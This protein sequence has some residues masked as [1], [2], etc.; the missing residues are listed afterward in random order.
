MV[1]QTLNFYK[2]LAICFVVLLHSGIGGWYVHGYV[3]VDFF[4]MLSGFFLARKI[5]E[6][7]TTI[8]TITYG[9]LSFKKLLPTH[10]VCLS[11]LVLYVSN[12]RFGNYFLTNSSIFFEYFL[13]HR[14]GFTEYF[15]NVPDWYLSSFLLVAIFLYASFKYFYY[16]HRLEIF[17]WM[18]SLFSLLFLVLILRLQGNLDVHSFLLWGCVDIGAI[19]C[20][21]DMV[22]GINCFLLLNY[23]KGLSSNIN[24][25]WGGANHFVELIILSAFLWVM[26]GKN[27]GLLIDFL[28]L[29]LFF[30]III[31]SF[32]TK[33]IVSQLASSSIFAR[34]YR[35]Q[36]P[37]YL[38]HFTV[39]IF[40]R[41]HP[42]TYW[43]E[44]VC[45]L[46][47][48]GY[49]ILIA[50]IVSFVKIINTRLMFLIKNHFLR[51]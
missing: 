14:W 50:R 49:A 35:L 39:L 4:F 44:I 45:L 28:S 21:V 29:V 40:I 8:D 24:V 11:I 6:K 20:Y 15:L 12:L 3:A 13:I 1:N 43:N 48:I 51:M 36:L 38:G 7:K 34:I 18:N 22:L 2:F 42:I 19:R 47:V 17:I 26:I 10:I 37:I 27:H 46:A 32:Y 5:I 16:K 31:S 23:L 9:V 33:G 41:E 30:I 25:V